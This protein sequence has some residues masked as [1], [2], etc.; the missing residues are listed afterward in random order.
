MST[1]FFFFTP[2][3]LF[4]LC[5]PNCS[6][7]QSKNSKDDIMNEIIIEGAY[8]QEMPSINPNGFTQFNIV[9]PLQ[10]EDITLISVFFKGKKGTFKKNDENYIALLSIPP[11]KINL[12]QPLEEKDFMKNSNK[13]ANTD[14]KII[15]ST[16]G[17]LKERIIKSLHRKTLNITHR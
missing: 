13:Q 9:F 4:I 7:S 8:Y 1:K 14:C 3:V 10:A 15:Y 17:I 11:K 6:S 5:S 2:I 16:N 12:K